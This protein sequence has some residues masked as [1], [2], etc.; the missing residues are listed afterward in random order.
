M[1][2]SLLVCVESSLVGAEQPGDAVLANPGQ[3]HRGCHVRQARLSVRA[4]D[5][6]GKAQ[7]RNRCGD[8]YEYVLADLPSDNVK[9]VYSVAIKI[10]F[11]LYKIMY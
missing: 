11:T 7:H 10:T 3:R 9:R 6:Q 8:V 1:S 4:Q 5:C 2:H